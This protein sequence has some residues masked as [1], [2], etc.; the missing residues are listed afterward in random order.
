MRVFA[1]VL[2][3]LIGLYYLN[4]VNG[5]CSRDSC[6]RKQYTP[7]KG[8]YH[9]GKVV[10]VYDNVPLRICIV[11]CRTYLECRSFNMNWI[12]PSRTF[13][14]CTLLEEVI[15]TSSETGAI[16]DENYTHYYWCPRDMVYFSTSGVC[17]ANKTNIDWYEG[18]QFCKSIYPGAHL[19]DIK[20]EQEQVAY[21][22]I[23]VLPF[24]R[25]PKDRKEE[26][27]ANSTGPILEIR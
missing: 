19:V 13:G 2:F 23:L 11:S 12:N 15:M 26:K 24:G 21:I 6:K 9:K 20:S 22:E 25:L 8:Y 14:T 17:L 27:A 7:I 3:L 16:Y 5:K 18:E 4:L 1:K 10:I